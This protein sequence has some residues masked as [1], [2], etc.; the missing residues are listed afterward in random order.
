MEEV[1]KNLPLKKKRAAKVDLGGF[2]EAKRAL[3]FK[4]SAK[5]RD[6]R[7][8]QLLKKMASKGP[9]AHITKA[10]RNASQQKWRA[11]KRQAA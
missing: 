8:N 10:K 3:H 5:R 9:L 2:T 6:Q 11:K 7:R 1:Q 4:N